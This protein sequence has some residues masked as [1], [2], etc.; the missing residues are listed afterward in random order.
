MTSESNKLKDRGN[1]AFKD[2]KFEKAIDLFK[3]AIEIEEASPS[4]DAELLAVLQSNIAQVYLE[5]KV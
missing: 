3:K 5:L 1:A 2:K 4:K